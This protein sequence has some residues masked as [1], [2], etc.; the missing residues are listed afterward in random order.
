MAFRTNFYVNIFLC[1]TGCKCITAVAC[2]CCLIIFRMYSFSHCIHLFRFEINIYIR[3][4]DGW[5]KS[6][7]NSFSILSHL[8]FICNKKKCQN[9]KFFKPW[10][11]TIARGGFEPSTLRVWTA[12]SSQL[13][14]L[15]II[16]FNCKSWD[17]QGS[18][19]W[20]SACKADALPAE[21]RSQISCRFA[22]R[23]AII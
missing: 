21:L 14:Y 12:C 23:F 8:L 13:S 4:I 18:N 6:R 3:A 10:H 2:N 22:T 7:T 5:I 19:L 15:A 11:F 20:P 16:W 1:R 17:L 9:S